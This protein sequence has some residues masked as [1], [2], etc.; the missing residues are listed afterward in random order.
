MK[1]LLT[2][3]T[4][5]AFLFLIACN[6]RSP[7]AKQSGTDSANQSESKSVKQ[8]ENRIEVLF[9]T[10]MTKDS[11]EKIQSS[12]KEKNIRLDYLE[13]KFDEGGHLTGLSFKVD[14]GDGYAGESGRNDLKQIKRFGFFRDY[15]QNADPPFAVGVLD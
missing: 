12:L 9:T 6:S 10:A 7:S 13:T 4:S 3:L 8:N 1:C 14:C 15:T 11:L 5:F 2:I